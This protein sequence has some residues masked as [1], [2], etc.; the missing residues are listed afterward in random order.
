MLRCALYSSCNH[1]GRYP[2]KK[3]SHLLAI[4]SLGF[5]PHYVSI[6]DGNP[7][8]TGLFPP[9]LRNTAHLGPSHR[10]FEAWSEAART[11]RLRKPA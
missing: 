4:P 5:A 7:K 3:V 8:V 6:I 1:Q 9:V 10:Y 11:I 2:T